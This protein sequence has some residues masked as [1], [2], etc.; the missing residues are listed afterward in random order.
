[1]STTLQTTNFYRGPHASISKILLNSSSSLSF[2]KDILKEFI[3][4]ENEIDKEYTFNKGLAIFYMLQYTSNKKLNDNRLWKSD[5]VEWVRALLSVFE[6][7]NNFLG[8]VGLAGFLNGYQLL[9]SNKKRKKIGELISEVENA[10]LKSIDSIVDQVNEDAKKETITYICAQCISFI[11]IAQLRELNSKTRL[12]H[13]LMSVVLENPRLFQDG[14]FLDEIEQDITKNQS[15]NAKSFKV[16]E[17]KVNDI[18]FKELS[19]ISLAISKLTQIVNN[20]DISSLLLRI[21]KFSINLYKTWDESPTLS[22]TKED[23][24]EPENKENMKL[25]WQVFKFIL[26][27]IT[28]IFKSIADRSLFEPHIFE[29]QE[30]MMILLA[31]SYLYFITSKFSLYGFSVYKKVFFN[32]LNQII[33]NNNSGEMIDII[34]N[35]ELDMNVYK[36][37]EK[38][39]VVYY[40]LVIEQVIKV[41]DDN[42]L[43]N[44]IL[45]A[46]DKILLNNDDDNIFESANAVILSIFYNQKR[47]I[48]ELSLYYCNYILS[49]YPSKIDIRQLRIAYTAVL[50]SL[51]DIDDTLVWLCLDILIKKIESISNPNTGS[52]S[53]NT[54]NK[55]LEQQLINQ[56]EQINQKLKVFEQ[57]KQDEQENL[58]KAILYLKKGHLLLTLIDQIK[59]INLIFMEN[60]LTKIKEFF[61]QEKENEIKSNSNIGLFA[62]QKVLFDVLSNEIDYTKK[63]VGVN[64][65]LNEGSKLLD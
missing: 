4:S 6:Y 42:Y 51:S 21:N 41:L 17:E 55:D 20:N 11:S 10:F 32:I 38:C 62:L 7:E 52:I 3:S 64:W 61:K 18:F 60:L 1:M 15:W 5:K 2:I 56:Q 22:L 39:R 35:I 13:L 33:V 59:S 47:V 40:L 46:F 29:N 27:T 19:K 65:W 54:T 34:K 49:M 14:K 26:F 12:M 45:P 16:L 8:F 28:M 44:H 36:P 58:V 31:Y 37:H 30:R 63:N 25:L 50:K 57:K 9:K 23:S 53:Q 24:L 48:K 43:E